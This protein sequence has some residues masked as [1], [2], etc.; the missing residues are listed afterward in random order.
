MCPAEE[1]F[2]AKL[3]ACRRSGTG[4]RRTEDASSSKDFG[5]SLKC[6]NRWPASQRASLRNLCRRPHLDRGGGEIW[7]L[8]DSSQNMP[9]QSEEFG[10]HN[11]WRTA[12]RFSIMSPQP[13][14][15]AFGGPELGNN[16]AET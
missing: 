8:N 16:L 6:G 10:Q 9:S 4:C 2:H 3:F 7:E 15:L 12:C 14:A 5:R 1:K 13:L 11:A